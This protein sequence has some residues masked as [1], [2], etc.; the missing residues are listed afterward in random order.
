[1]P[2]IIPFIPLIASVAGPLMSK[3]IGGSDSSSSSGGGSKSVTT[4]APKQLF[5]A[6]QIKSAQDQYTTTGNAKW[7]Q[8]LA[9][10][11]GGDPNAVSGVSSAISDQ[12]K[13]LGTSLGGLTTA[14]GYG[15]DPMANLAGI[16]SGVEGG[17]DAKYKVY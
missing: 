11:G 9:N 13:A 16:L 12:A 4:A 15:S 3:L 6:D 14:S 17:I 1:M 2:Q 10:M 8:I 5:N 7:N